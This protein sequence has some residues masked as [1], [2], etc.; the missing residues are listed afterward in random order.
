M[1]CS[2]QEVDTRGRIHMPQ[3]RHGSRPWRG[4]QPNPYHAITVHVSP[5]PR[6]SVPCHHS[7]CRHQLHR[8]PGWRKPGTGPPQRLCPAFL[9]SSPPAWTHLLACNIHLY[10]G[11]RVSN[12]SMDT[13]STHPRAVSPP[14][15][16]HRRTHRKKKVTIHNFFITRLRGEM[17]HTTGTCSVYM[18]SNRSSISPQQLVKPCPM[19]CMHCAIPDGEGAQVPHHS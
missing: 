11:F 1:S 9:G 17:H 12:A 7:P 19:M 2:Q 8:P 13:R 5:K 18:K 10:L 15:P 4:T 3:P 16:Y 6:C 14:Y